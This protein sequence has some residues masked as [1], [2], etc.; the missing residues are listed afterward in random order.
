M[1]NHYI[2]I[3][4]DHTKINLILNVYSG[5]D[6]IHESETDHNIDC[7]MTKQQTQKSIY[8]KGLK[9]KKHLKNQPQLG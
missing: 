4:S 8:L 1:I 6:S 5:P 3:N 9:R 7:I 2:F